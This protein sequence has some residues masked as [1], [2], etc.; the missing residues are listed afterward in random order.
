[1]R[2]ENSPIPEDWLKV[3]GVGRTR[4]YGRRD[5]ERL[6]K[7]AGFRHAEAFAYG[8]TYDIAVK[9]AGL[10]KQIGAFQSA[11]AA[12]EAKLAFTLRLGSGPWLF[13]VAEK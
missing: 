3:R 6:Y 10:L 2:Q 1:M 11:L 12:A 7:R 8:Q 4:H 13:L 5:L 9:Q